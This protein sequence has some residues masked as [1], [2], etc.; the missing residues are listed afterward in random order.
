MFTFGGSTH[1]NYLNYI[2]ETIVGLELESMPGLKAALLRGLIWNLRGLPGYC[3]EGDYIVEFF[4]RLLEDVTEHKSAQFDDL[5]IR[6]IISRNL[7]HLAELKVAWWT[8]VG[9]KKKAH[10]HSDPHTRP[11]MLIL[12]KLYRDTELHSCRLGLQ[13]DDRDTDDFARG[14]KKLREGALQTGLARTAAKRQVLRTDPAPPPAN[15]TSDDSSD[16][17][18]TDV[19]S[20]SSDSDPEDDAGITQFYATRGSTYMVD[21]ELVFDERDM[22]AGPEDDV[23]DEDED[24]AVG[25]DD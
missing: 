8:G 16:S 4:N 17:D 2:L 24:F 22:L 12:L 10:K 11:E 13:I 1:T 15:P 5:F 6:N 7:R 14:V 21:G 20:E 25:D 18:D 23:E 9:M 3:E 19:E